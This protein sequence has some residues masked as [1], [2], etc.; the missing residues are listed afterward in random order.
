MS[1]ISDRLTEIRARI[2][3]AAQS[4]GRDPASVR[5]VAVSKTFPIESIAEAFAADVVARL[6]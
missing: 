5:L 1:N 6:R 4:A 2:S 3:A